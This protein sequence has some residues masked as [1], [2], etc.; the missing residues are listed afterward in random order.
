MSSPVN[1]HSSL[2]ITCEE[3]KEITDG[4]VVP[5][6]TVKWTE[7]SLDS[8]NRAKRYEIPKTGLGERFARAVLFFVCAI[9]FALA[10]LLTHGISMLCTMNQQGFENKLT[11]GVRLD[12]MRT[13]ESLRDQIEGYLKESITLDTLPKLQQAQKKWNIEGLV[14]RL[15]ARHPD[16]KTTRGNKPTSDSMP[17]ITKIPVPDGKTVMGGDIKLYENKA[18][19]IAALHKFALSTFQ[20]ICSP[21]PDTTAVASSCQPSG[22]Y[23]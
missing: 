18:N 16:I 6:Y 17:A 12:A 23:A 8:A 19:E 10:H 15:D 14:E 22:C 3:F 13:S 5:I 21:G 7:P 9:G 2:Q 1:L 20:I 11:F 4:T